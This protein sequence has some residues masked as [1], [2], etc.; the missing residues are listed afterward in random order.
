MN[1]SDAVITNG[2]GTFTD[3]VGNTYADYNEAYYANT[4]V[5]GMVD[6]YNIEAGPAAPVPAASDVQ[7]TSVRAIINGTSSVPKTTGGVTP[8]TNVSGWDFLS[9]LATTTFQTAGQALNTK[10]AQDAAIQQ[11]KVTA[12]IAAI[13]KPAVAPGTFPTGTVLILGALALGGLLLVSMAGRR[14]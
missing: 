11:A 6:D 5:Y 4:D 3:A 7:P 1:A 9:G 8:G 10:L 2:D 14:S 13:N 12:Q